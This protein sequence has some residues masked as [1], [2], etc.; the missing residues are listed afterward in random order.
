MLQIAK[1]QRPKLE[2]EG[3]VRWKEII[4][5]SKIREEQSRLNK[6]K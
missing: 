1:I 4:I 5:E 6:Q 3:S 2:L